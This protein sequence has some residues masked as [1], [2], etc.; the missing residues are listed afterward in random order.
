MPQ[1]LNRYKADLREIK[2]V[3][4]EQLGLAELLAGRY[5]DWDEETTNAV[6]DEV[7]RFACEV[8]GP[9]AAIGDYEGCKLVDGEV[10]TP[11]GFKQAW[12][13]LYAAG[14]KSLSAPAELGGQGAPRVIGAAV[15]FVSVVR[16]G[17]VLVL[18]LHAAVAPQASCVSRTMSE[19][20]P[21]VVTTSTEVVAGIVT[22]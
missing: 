5:G 7:Y 10:K 1:P 20:E 14:W 17:A 19:P 8:S 21:G 4:F 12:D 22:E 16:S 15:V 3:L 13:K 6:I 9:Y 11:S 2:F 18:K